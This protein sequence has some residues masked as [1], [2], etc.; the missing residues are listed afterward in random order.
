[1]GLGMDVAEMKIEA[2]L[3]ISAI[4]VG[5]DEILILVAPPDSF[6]IPPDADEEWK[7]PLVEELVSLG[8]EGRC[9]VI[10]ADGVQMAKVKK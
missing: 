6:Y 4:T 2:T 7:D 10:Y 1:M 9:L 8:L 3:D 5:P